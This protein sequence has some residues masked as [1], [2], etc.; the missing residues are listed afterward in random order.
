MH[1]VSSSSNFLFYSVLLYVFYFFAFLAFKNIS[2]I[3]F[4][5]LMIPIIILFCHIFQAV[6]SGG[7]VSDEVD[8]FLVDGVVNPGHPGIPADMTLI[9]SATLQTIRE[10]M[11]ASLRRMKQLE[12]ENDAMR[13]LEVCNS[14]SCCCFCSSSSSSSGCSSCSC[15]CRCMY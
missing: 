3:M 15:C 11:A 13:M 12:D 9:S 5:T 6:L 2:F 4:I 10:Q 7:E 14:S 8:T 1:L